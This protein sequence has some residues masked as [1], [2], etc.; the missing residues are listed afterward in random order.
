MDQ[1]LAIVF[2]FS[3][4]DYA[5]Y[6][7]VA[8]FSLLLHAERPAKI[9]CLVNNVDVT[10]L[11]PIVRI[12]ARFGAT[13]DIKHTAEDT[14]ADW[15]EM[16]H[17]SRATY[18]RLLIPDLVPERQVLYLDSDLIVTCDVSPLM[19]VG[20]EG[21]C[22]AGVEEPGVSSSKVPRGA[23]D[24]YINTG[25]M[26]MD[27]EALRSKNFVARCREIYSQYEPLITWADQC[28]INKFA[29]GD[30]K[31][32]D[33][34]WN[35]QTNTRPVGLAYWEHEIAIHD[36]VGIIHFNGPVKPWHGWCNPWPSKF[37]W[38]YAKLAKIPGLAPIEPSTIDHALY[39]A[40]VLDEEGHFR[41]AS[42]IKSEVLRM[43]AGEHKPAAAE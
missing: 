26:L 30:K 4:G 43:L 31:L 8:L 9:Y 19:S 6:T 17:F 15:K 41:Q 27:L 38:S 37:W 36:G 18:L 10:Q 22:I 23:G 28:V 7:A 32:I 42:Q 14:F 40:A 13:L 3:G 35:V 1:R 5:K 16:H 34:V 29:E 20:L 39:M 12:A 21:C 2:C 25:V 33:R 24:P 11:S